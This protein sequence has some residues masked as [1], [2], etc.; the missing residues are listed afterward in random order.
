MYSG[1]VGGFK[2]SVLRVGGRGFGYL[3][4]T[5]WACTVYRVGGGQAE[6]EGTDKEEGREGGE[7]HARRGKAAAAEV[8][9]AAGALHRAR[10]F[11]RPTDRPTQ[12]GPPARK[13]G[14]LGQ[15]ERRK[16]PTPSESGGREGVRQVSA[17]S[18][19]QQIYL[20]KKCDFRL[21][22]AHTMGVHGI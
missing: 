14:C 6:H 22:D 11:A 16:P 17:A 9:T 21:H 13:A 15:C 7:R 12:D 2:L 18:F 8:T 10:P 3:P 1:W 20:Q 4:R 5:R 19:F